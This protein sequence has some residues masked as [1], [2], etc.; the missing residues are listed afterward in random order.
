LEASFPCS[1]AACAKRGNVAATEV[2]YREPMLD[3]AVGL[4][5]DVWKR[6]GDA[7]ERVD[8]GPLLPTHGFAMGA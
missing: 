5:D 1:S 4:F 3:G 2:G 7:A 6:G 8:A